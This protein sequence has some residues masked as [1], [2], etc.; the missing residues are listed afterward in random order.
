MEAHSLQSPAIGTVAATVRRPLRPRRPRL[1]TL[2]SRIVAC[3][4]L[5]L[6]TLGTGTTLVASEM[7]SNRLW[8]RVADGL[9]EEIQDFDQFTAVRGGRAERLPAP[10]LAGAHLDAFV[11]DNVPDHE[12]AI[13]TFA[14]GELRTAALQQFPPRT[15]PAAL[16]QR[17]ADSTAGRGAPPPSAGRFETPLG[18]AMYRI[19]RLQD[20]SGT[21]GALVLA[22]LPA[23]ELREVRSLRAAGVAATAAMI[24]LGAL[25]AHLLA[26]RLLGPMRRL[27]RTA[28]TISRSDLGPRVPIRGDDEIAE[29]G[30]SFNAMVDRLEETLTDT[31]DQGREAAHELRAPLTVCRCQLM[32]IRDGLEDPAQPARIALLEIDRMSRLVD[33]LEMLGELRRPELVARPFELAEWTCDGF[34]RAAALAPRG[35]LL[36]SIGDATLSGDPDMLA[37]ALLNLAR[38]AAQ[39]TGEGARIEV[40]SAAGDGEARVWVRDSGPG[41]P[42]ADRVHIFERFARGR[43]T[44]ARYAGAGLGLAIARAVAEAHGGRIELDSPPGAGATFTI[45][46]PRE[47]D[48]R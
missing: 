28:R 19:R 3:T 11:A 12:Q 48:G 38:N 21:E 2:R 5:L 13:V 31:R 42:G 32:L 45:V 41:V 25:A 39:H 22:N 46:L 14:A 7:L 23:A 9:A 8:D 15:L 44:S 40:G 26:G 17:W 47:A 24:L 16:V 27:T 43:D 35:W 34:E 33:D 10:V 37:Q 6:T 1:S 29:M 36:T 4:V 30:S 18:P 20:S